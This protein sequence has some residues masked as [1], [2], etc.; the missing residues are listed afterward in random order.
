MRSNTRDYGKFQSSNDFLRA[1]VLRGGIEFDFCGRMKI[2]AS[3]VFYLGSIACESRFWR[4]TRSSGRPAR[5]D[6]PRAYF[7]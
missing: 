7:G 5:Q 4:S 2:T 6:R 1:E 3:A